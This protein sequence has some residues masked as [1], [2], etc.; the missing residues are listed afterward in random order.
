VARD[1]AARVGIA[2]N[3]NTYGAVVADFDGDGIDDLYIGRHG[4]PGRLLLNRDGKFVQHAPMSFPP[5]DRHGCTAADIDG[6]GLP[7][8]HCAIGGK[9]GS[10]FKSNE[11]WI[12]P[13]GPAPYDIAA[14]S[15]LADPTGRGRDSVFLEARRQD[16]VNLVVTNSPTRVDGLPSIGRLYRTLGDSDFGA[17][18]R[19]GFASRL[20]SVTMQ[21]ADYDGDGREDLLLVTGGLQAPARQGTR[22]YRNT[23]RGLVDVTRRLG[24]R[25]FGE[26]DAKLVD[27][28]GDSMLDL[29]QLS[30]TR[31]RVSVF[32]GGR[33]REAYLRSLTHGRAV[34]AGDI[35][36]DGRDDLY[37]V[38][39]DHGRNS[40]DIMLINQADG[41]RFS[42]M[43]I[44]QASSGDAAEAVAIDHDGN[45][46]DDFVVLNGRNT[47]GPIQLIAFFKR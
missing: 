8:L 39:G 11:L 47:R 46:R 15:G 25:S 42:S 45:G 33:F 43:T 32:K 10:G 6:S 26:V 16:D 37:V 23:K 5:I 44:P 28:D 9:G 24:I 14:E 13:G 41:R 7:D 19:T 2:E 29:V 21:D 34:G 1:V 4:R 31:L 18:A 27:I 36:A 40:A 17:R 3:I 38:R 12:D 35:N 20:G 30:P 22:L